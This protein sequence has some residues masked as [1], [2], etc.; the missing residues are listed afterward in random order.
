MTESLRALLTGLIDYAGLFP[1]AKLDMATNVRNYA[2]YLAGD[3]AFALGRMKCPITRLDELTEH[4]AI[5]MPGTYATS[6]YT[7][8]AGIGGPWSISGIVTTD[9]DPALDAI[10]LFSRATPDS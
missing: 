9:L 5:V 4:G 8:M 3:H 1:P 7:E 2:T 6:G 10:G